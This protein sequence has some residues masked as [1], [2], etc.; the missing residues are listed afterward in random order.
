GKKV[1][2]MLR[3]L[4]QTFSGIISGVTNF[5]MFVELENTVEGMVSLTSMTDDYYDYDP[6]AFRLVGK[7]TNKVYRL[8]DEVTVKVIRAGVEDRQIDFTLTE[9]QEQSRA[10]EKRLGRTRRSTVSR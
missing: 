9:I 1:E 6:A 8:G 4:G 10:V 3:H 5:G 7:R 2:Y